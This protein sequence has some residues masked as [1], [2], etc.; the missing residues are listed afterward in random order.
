M[1]EPVEIETYTISQA[2]ARHKGLDRNYFI[3]RCEKGKK[4]LEE[5]GE[6]ENVPLRERTR[7][8]FA[9]K[10]GGLWIIPAKEL[11]RLFL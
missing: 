7:V 8:L 6:K 9:K 5:Y 4:L 2:M 10:S 3:R 1:I 11:D